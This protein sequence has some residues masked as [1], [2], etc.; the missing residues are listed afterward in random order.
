[1]QY[2][3]KGLL[4]VDHRLIRAGEEF[5][6][7]LPPGSKWEPLDDAAQAK[8][9]ERDRLAAL[10]AEQAAAKAAA[11]LPPDAIPIPTDWIEMRPEQIVNL[12]RRLGAFGRCNYAQAVAWIEKVVAARTEQANAMKGAA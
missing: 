4:F 7:D 3:A 8:C 5:E 10:A 9:E 2:R 6:S 12:A 1:M 11:E